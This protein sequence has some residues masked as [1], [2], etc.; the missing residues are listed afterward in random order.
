MDKKQ[1]RNIAK[2]YIRYLRKNNFNVEKVY[3]FG[4][5]AR[6]SFKEDS[7]IDLAVVFQEYS[8]GFDM[9][10]QLLKL[11]RNFDTRIEPHP[12]R[13]SDFIS[14]NPLVNEIL[15]TGLQIM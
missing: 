8:D 6:G 11:R 13:S 5:Y 2:K 1:A 4:S 12:F 14:S 3:L 9:Q 10:V 15:S 7:D